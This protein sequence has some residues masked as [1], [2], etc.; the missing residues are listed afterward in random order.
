MVQFAYP[1]G[2]DEGGC[3]A[4]GQR[5]RNNPQL[6]K[7]IVERVSEL[8]FVQGK[9]EL[10]FKNDHHVSNRILRAIVSEGHKDR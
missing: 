2:I 4:A 3:S 5:A 6:G 9:S 10:L 7:L 1:K 8:V